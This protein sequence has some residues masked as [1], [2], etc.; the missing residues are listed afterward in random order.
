MSLRKRRDRASLYADFGLEEGS[1]PREFFQARFERKRNYK[2]QQVSREVERTLHYLFNSEKAGEL[3]QDLNLLYVEPV[4]NSSHL[5]VVVSPGAESASR[6]ELEILE[7]LQKACGW[8]RQEIGAT[9]HRRKVPDLS[10]R[11]LPY[12]APEH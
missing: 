2:A 8:L 7:V 1:D 5:V 6:S 3:L 9:L 4:P 11:V 10:F 12:K